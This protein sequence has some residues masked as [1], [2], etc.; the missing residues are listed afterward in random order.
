M[1]RRQIKK[2]SLVLQVISAGKRERRLA[3]KDSLA[4]VQHHVVAELGDRD[5]SWDSFRI[6]NSKASADFTGQSVGY[7]GMRYWP[8]ASGLR[9]FKVGKRL[10][11]RSAVQS[12]C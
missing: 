1:G 6:R 7:L 12:H 9:H 10:K 5:G 4:E 11:S 3:V 8:A 2:W